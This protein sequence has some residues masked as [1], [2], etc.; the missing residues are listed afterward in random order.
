MDNLSDS[1]YFQLIEIVSFFFSENIRSAY[2]IGLAV[3]L[4][5]RARIELNYCVPLQKQATDK[6]VNGFQFGIG[7]EFV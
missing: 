6:A 2:G 3:K 7:Y 5:E 1:E 4:A